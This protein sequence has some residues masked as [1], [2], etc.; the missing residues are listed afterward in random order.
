M[1]LPI[2]GIVIIIDNG[3]PGVG[4]SAMQMDALGVGR[5]VVLLEFSGRTCEA[6]VWN[7]YGPDSLRG[8]SH[9]R[10]TNSVARKLGC[11]IDDE[12]KFVRVVTPNLPVNV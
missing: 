1:E 6:K 12:I 11:G 2:A 3:E 8:A 5:G 4:L 7:A 10:I 9:V